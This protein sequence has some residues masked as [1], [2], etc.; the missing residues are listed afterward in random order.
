MDNF[1]AQPTFPLRTFPEDERGVFILLLAGILVALITLLGLAVD[2]G[3]L[4]NAQ[5]SAQSA[6]DAAVSSGA[7]LL[8][9][10]GSS[11]NV[12]DIKQAMD[13][14]AETN[15]VIKNLPSDSRRVK[16][17]SVNTATG[18]VSYSIATP[19]PLRIMNIIP[20]IGPH[21]T[22]S[23]QA[24][25]HVR[26]A[27]VSLM[28]DT[29]FSMCCPAGVGNCNPQ[30]NCPLAGSRM[31]SLIGAVSTFI[32]HFDPARDS[33]N[34]IPYSLGAEVVTP[35][36]P[37]GTGFQKA[38]LLAQ[39]QALRPGGAT[40]L[41]DAFLRS[42]YDVERIGAQNRT[43]YV[44]FSDGAPTAA[45]FLLSYN[46]VNNPVRQLLKNDILGKGY[47][48]F[49]YLSWS[50]LSGSAP[51]IQSVPYYFVFT[52]TTP[53]PW[54]PRTHTDALPPPGATVL[55]RGPFPP[56]TGT[57]LFS[58]TVTYIEYSLPDGSD[59][60]RGSGW[61]YA[62]GTMDWPK[63]NYKTEYFNY[64]LA[65]A[66]FVRLQGG[67][68]FAIGLGTPA[69]YLIDPVTGNPDPYQNAEVD[70]DRKDIFFRRMTNDSCGMVGGDPDFPGFPTY[71]QLS[72]DGAR[73]GSYLPTPSPQEL[74][75]LF[76]RVAR[77]IKMQLVE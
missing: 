71:S 10:Q 58:Y 22:V 2:A 31:E 26:P 37:L 49:D 57:A 13:S 40:N 18:M 65:L 20:G 15:L 28:L 21:G 74:N 3:T 4:Y 59:V 70:F 9:Q 29:S 73:E 38:Q 77:Q 41:S 46:S 5:L 42:W 64:P 36:R 27:V 76:E 19:V 33:I 14:V 52:P 75:S 39:A 1:T 56:D 50:V 45:R 34:L 67:S 11:A 24:R 66:D 25:A 61:D 7:A 23:A 44:V 63:F 51:N 12:N 32:D 53:G 55:I 8:S 35:F 60:R 68:I 47:S 54:N 6:A 69:P 16:T 72:A 43:A 62:T 17:P 48:M 30:P